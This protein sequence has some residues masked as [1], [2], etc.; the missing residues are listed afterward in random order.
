MDNELKVKYLVKIKMTYALAERMFERK[1][2]LP[3]VVFRHMGCCAG[4]AY[5]RENVIHLNEV[6][7]ETQE[8]DMLGDTVPHEVAHLIAFE[9]YKDTGHGGGWKSIMRTLGLE[10]SRCHDYDTT[11]VARGRNAMVRKAKVVEY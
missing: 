10:P 4:K 7:C 11:M 1:F 8:V 3:G 9:M 5:L 6:F 2:N